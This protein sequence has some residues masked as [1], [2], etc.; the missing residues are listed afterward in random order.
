MAVAPATDT[1]SS[2]PTYFATRGIVIKAI[3]SLNTLDKNAN[4][5]SSTYPSAKSMVEL[6]EYQPKPDPMAD[7]A[8]KKQ[9]IGI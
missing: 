5:L 3:I 2:F 7:T 6:K 9:A 8:C 4:A 1:D